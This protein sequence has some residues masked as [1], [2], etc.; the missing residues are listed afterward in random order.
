M[1]GVSGLQLEAIARADGQRVSQENLSLRLLAEKEG[2]WGERGAGRI[3]S[4]QYSETKEH[5]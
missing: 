2:S 5:P 4:E 3:K 1:S